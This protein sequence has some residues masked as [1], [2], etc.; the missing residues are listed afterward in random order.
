MIRLKIP[1]RTLFALT[2]ILSLAL[3][4]ACGVSNQINTGEVYSI[5][6]SGKDGQEADKVQEKKACP[7]QIGLQKINSK[8]DLI[9]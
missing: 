8:T 3:L 4:K 5:S 1:A 2:L 9:Q 6:L 7:I